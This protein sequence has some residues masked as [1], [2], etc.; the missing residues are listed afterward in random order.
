MQSLRFS[1]RKRTHARDWGLEKKRQTSYKDDARPPRL[2]S[3]SPFSS[4]TA[5][6]L[7]YRT[8]VAQISGSEPVF[9]R[10]ARQHLWNTCTSISITWQITAGNSWIFLTLVQLKKIQI[11]HLSFI[12]RLFVVVF[13]SSLQLTE[14]EPSKLCGGECDNTRCGFYTQQVFT[15]LFFQ[16]STD[17]ASLKCQ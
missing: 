5:V 6:L 16:L 1:N 2:S 13:F 11:V 17:I 15:G 7:L 10:A 14:R 9:S 4:W 12:W 3:H 8:S